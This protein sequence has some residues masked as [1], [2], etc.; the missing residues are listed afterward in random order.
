LVEVR[1]P[2][3]PSHVRGKQHLLLAIKVFLLC[4]YPA[5]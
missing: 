5:R 1:Y 2:S 4:C 3:C